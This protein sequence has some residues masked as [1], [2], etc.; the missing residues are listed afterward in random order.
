AMLAGAALSYGLEYAQPLTQQ[1]GIDVLEVESK[2]SL[3][4]SSVVLGKYLTPDLYIGYITDLFGGSPA[5]SVK[6][7]LTKHLSVE[8]RSGTSQSLDLRYGIEHD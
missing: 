4:D 2:E 1:I 8:S 3:K 5:V 6:Y 7:R